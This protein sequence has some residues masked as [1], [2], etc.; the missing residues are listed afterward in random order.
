M[1]KFPIMLY[2]T[3]ST[4]KALVPPIPPPSSYEDAVGWSA[5]EA[6]YKTAL[7]GS[8]KFTREAV[9]YDLYSE[10]NNVRLWRDLKKIE[11]TRQAGV[12]EYTPG[13]YRHRI[14]MEPKERSLHIPPLRER[15]EDI[16]P[17]CRSLLDELSR[18]LKR[19]LELTPEALDRLLAH[20]WPGNVRE[21]RNVLEFCAYLTPSGLITELSLPE[22]LRTAP[23]AQPLTLAQRTRAFEKQEILRLLAC[24]GSHL[25]GKK[26]TA[27]Q[28]G[29]SLASLYNK[30]NGS[31]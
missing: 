30:L 2:N 18:K 17:L 19:R 27:A 21:L 10:V 23:A 25:E 6:G 9:L 15:R 11:K 20:N 3:K 14:I 28:L 26:K 8:R 5:I 16:P 22:N 13:K 1:T 12:S 31:F 7:R 29:I 24:N 4:K